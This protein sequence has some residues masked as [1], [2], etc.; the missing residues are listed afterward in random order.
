MSADRS[1]LPS[2]ERID[3]HSV[4]FIGEDMVAVSKFLEF[5]AAA[6]SGIAH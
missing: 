2:V 1:Y 6:L 5:A 3:A 4:R